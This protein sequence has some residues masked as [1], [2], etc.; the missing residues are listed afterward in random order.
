MTD[1]IRRLHAAVVEKDWDTV[2]GVSLD[3][4]AKASTPLQREAVQRLKDAA[5]FG[6]VS[7]ATTYVHQAFIKG[8]PGVDGWLR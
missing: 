8:K 6:A 3:L 7:R 2:R 1:A 4:D 5:D